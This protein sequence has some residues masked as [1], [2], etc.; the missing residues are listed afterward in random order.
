MAEVATKITEEKL[1]HLIEEWYKLEDQTIGLS[2]DLKKKSDN[3]FVKVIAEIIEH[4]SK[5]HKIMQQFIIDALSKEAVRLAPQELIPLADVLEKH[6]QAEAK[7]VGMA[8]ACSTVSRNYFV[9]FMLSVLT[10]DEIKH[11]NMLKT[12]DHIK[13]AIYPYGQTREERLGGARP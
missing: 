11:H 5:K 9:D 8:H 7:S 4:D 6:I 3:P 12:L 10:D 13:G 1:L 2:E